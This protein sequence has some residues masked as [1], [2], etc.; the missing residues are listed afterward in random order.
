MEFLYID[1]CILQHYHLFIASNFLVE[2]LGFVIFLYEGFHI[3]FKV[4]LSAPYQLKSKKWLIFPL[5]LFLRE[6][7]ATELTSSGMFQV[8]LYLPKI[9]CP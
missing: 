3:V 1:F 2:S 7:W 9:Y 5:H 4:G 6:G 8:H